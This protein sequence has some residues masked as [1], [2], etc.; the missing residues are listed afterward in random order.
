MSCVND[1]THWQWELLSHQQHHAK[2]VERLRLK[3]VGRDLSNVALSWLFPVLQFSSLPVSMPSSPQTLVQLF[4]KHRNER[5]SFASERTTIPGVRAPAQVCSHGCP[6]RGSC[7]SAAWR[8]EALCPWT[9]AVLSCSL[10]LCTYCECQGS[11]RRT[12]AK[13]RLSQVYTNVSQKCK[14]FWVTCKLCF[15]LLH[16]WHLQF[17]SPEQFSVIYSRLLGFCF[18]FLLCS[19]FSPSC[20]EWKSIPCNK[21]NF[22]MFFFQAMGPVQLP[23]ESG[24]R[25]G[26][27]RG[28]MMPG[29]QQ[30]A[31]RWVEGCLRWESLLPGSRFQLLVRFS[32]TLFLLWYC[33]ALD[34][35]QQGLTVR[36]MLQEQ[37]VCCCSSGE[38]EKCA[39]G[40]WFQPWPN[41][42]TQGE[43]SGSGSNTT[44]STTG[45]KTWTS[46]NLKHSC[47]DQTEAWLPALLLSHLMWV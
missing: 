14:L 45:C 44:A 25:L 3:I 1:P 40:L 26:M 43:P 10:R 28:W 20:A 23:S 2:E 5:G 39:G 29:E 46:L 31:L 38:A 30:R 11:P 33:V 4:P 32:S 19:F 16:L 18:S 8:E 24:S 12:S 35:D 21:M 7:T 22:L 15:E 9:P 41:S 47:K 34:K 13:H 27:L 42:G 36:T 37:V 17:S 6:G